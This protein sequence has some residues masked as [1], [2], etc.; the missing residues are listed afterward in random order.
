MRF[1]ALQLEHTVIF[2]Q[3]QLHLVP[4]SSPITYRGAGS[5]QRRPEDPVCQSLE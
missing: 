3:E 5:Q 2:T 1:L 4:G